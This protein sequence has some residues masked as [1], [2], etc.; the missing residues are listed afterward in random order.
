VGPLLKK[1]KKSEKILNVTVFAIPM[2]L[3]T[4]RVYLRNLCS[5]KLNTIY[6]AYIWLDLLIFVKEI[7]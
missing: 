2:L 6:V 4:N 5:W 7:Y 3:L 1:V